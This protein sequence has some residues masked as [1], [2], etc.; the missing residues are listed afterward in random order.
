MAMDG[1]TL[2]DRTTTE[3]E[4]AVTSTRDFSKTLSRRK[5]RK[6]VLF[7]GHFKKSNWGNESTLQAILYHIRRYL[8]EVEIECVCTGPEVTAS[9]YQIGAIPIRDHRAKFW[10]GQSRLANL[11][12][13]VILGLPR[14]LCQWF[15][16]VR[17]LRETDIFIIPG[18]GLL[19]D[20]CGLMSWGP[21]N[22]L[23]WSLLAKI[24]GCKVCFVSVGAGPIR[25]PLGRYLVKTALSLAD[26]RS[27]RDE[28]TRSYLNRLGIDTSND[29][30]YPDLVFSF[31]EPAT[32][33]HHVHKMRRPLVGV[34]V[35]TYVGN[36]G[37]PK[38]NVLAHRRYQET[39]ATFIAWLLANEY[40]VKLLTGDVADV[41][42]GEELRCLLEE[43]LSPEEM[44]RVIYEPPS[45]VEELLTQL[46]E[47]DVVVA[48]R[49]H[50]VLLSLLLNKP[51][52]SISFHQKCVSLMRQMRLSQYCLRL[53]TVTA[54]KLIEQFQK[55]ES[56]THRLKPMIRRRA[57]RFRSMLDEQYNR[58][59]E[60]E[61]L[62]AVKTTSSVI[63]ISK[64]AVTSAVSRR[65]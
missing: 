24:C 39:L 1:I 41:S 38:T 45:S 36:Y 22:M 3:S 29:P 23:K 51:V 14:E 44:Q 52:I 16:H 2:L 33:N 35:M 28:F 20:A 62:D 18:T 19:T 53:N 13:K 32:S 17:V 9:T 5:T 11:L 40:D 60:S 21:Y 42:V 50:N 27:Y 56:N 10:T 30:V 46:A 64:R 49:F 34:G 15:K 26:F 4:V 55:L 12:H 54:D 65:Y 63:S 8:P 58:I 61:N 59:F 25:T 7:F 6:K 37:F 57:Q 48:T 43:R 47:T 31:P